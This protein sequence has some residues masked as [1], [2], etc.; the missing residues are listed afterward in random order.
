MRALFGALA[1]GN[2]R[3][4]ILLLGAVSHAENLSLYIYLYIYIYIYL[5]L[6]LALSLSSPLGFRQHDT[7]FAPD[8]LTDNCGTQWL[9]TRC[10]K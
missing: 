5:S 7:L 2:P 1:S 4:L 6:S 3:H 10:Q 8:L 9:N